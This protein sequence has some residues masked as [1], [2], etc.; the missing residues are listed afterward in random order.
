[1][2]EVLDQVKVF[3]AKIDEATNT[4]ADRIQTLQ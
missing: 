3:A 4:I 2:S 1:M